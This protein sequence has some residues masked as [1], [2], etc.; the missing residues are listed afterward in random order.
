MCCLHRGMLA[1]LFGWRHRWA[2]PYA[3]FIGITE[4][5]HIPYNLALFWLAFKLILN[6]IYFFITKENALAM[7]LYKGLYMIILIH[8]P[9]YGGPVFAH[10]MCLV[11]SLNINT[12]LSRRNLYWF[13]INRFYLA[14]ALQMKGQ[15]SHKLYDNPFLFK[16]NTCV[17]L[18]QL[19]VALNIYY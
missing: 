10:H 17:H 15:C 11:S 16:K 13:R 8:V 1:A 5:R 12:F 3:A 6:Y 14:E 19:F 2:T 7:N 9:P 4:Y 18:I